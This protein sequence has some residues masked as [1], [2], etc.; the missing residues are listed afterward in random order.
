MGRALE[1]KKELLEQQAMKALEALAKLQEMQEQFGDNDDYPDGTVLRWDQTYQK[2]NRK[3]S[4]VAIKCAGFW[5]TS[6]I[7]QNHRMTFDELIE[8]HLQHNVDG[9]FY[10]T[11]WTAI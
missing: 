11:E 5:Y 9:V 2:N 1:I 8:K 6:G 4:F 3:Y 7:F 10:C